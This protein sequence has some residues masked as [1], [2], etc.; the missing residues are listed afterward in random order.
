MP[1][2]KSDLM[3]IVALSCKLELFLFKNKKNENKNC[4]LSILNILK[5]LIADNCTNKFYYWKSTKK[6]REKTILKI[7]KSYV[8]FSFSAIICHENLSRKN[9]NNLPWRTKTLFFEGEKS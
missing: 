2:C 3:V 9:K 5:F 6:F 4:V 1:L 8:W 7:L